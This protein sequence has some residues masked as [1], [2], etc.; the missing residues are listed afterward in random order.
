MTDSFQLPSILLCSSH[1]LLVQRI[2]SSTVSQDLQRR[3]VQ[4]KER[5]QGALNFL[6]PGGARSS[7]PSLHHPG[8]RA[9]RLTARQLVTVCDVFQGGSLNRWLQTKQYLC[10]RY[11][12]R[13]LHGPIGD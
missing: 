12:P 2:E 9:S 8:Q 11:G 4:K 7:T 13:Y 5:S 6:A 3:F 1:P 10:S